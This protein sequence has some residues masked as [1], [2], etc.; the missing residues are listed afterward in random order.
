TNNRWDTHWMLDSPLNFTLGHIDEPLQM[1][2][3]LLDYSADP[4]LPDSNENTPL[5]IAINQGNT[6]LVKVIL[7]YG[8]THNQKD[9]DSMTPLMRAAKRHQPEIIDL[10]F[11]AMPRQQYI[12]EIMLL[13]SLYQLTYRPI[14]QVLDIFH[15]A[16]HLQSENLNNSIPCEAYEFRR[17]CQTF[18][19]LLNIRN[20]AH[21]MT[22]QALLL[23]NA[24]II[25]KE[26]KQNLVRLVRQ[27]VRSDY[28]KSFPYEKVLH[29]ALQLSGEIYHSA[30]LTT[31][32]NFIRFM[33]ACGANVNELTKY[34][35]QR[36]L[37]TIAEA[38]NIDCA[39]KIIQILLKA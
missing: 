21:A 29:F 27:V 25:T 23:C 35:G 5:H 19:E 32:E 7:D 26:E 24:D 33:V 3:C 10:L 16:F 11:A 22:I 30:H 15:E 20:D 8:F 28:R 17:E 31:D 18:D 1:V 37:H 38:Y 14:E 4:T 12:D 39:I 6:Q 34:S 9:M 13:A 2:K 36:P